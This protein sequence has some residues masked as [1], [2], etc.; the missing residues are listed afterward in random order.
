MSV[1]PHVYE[2]SAVFVDDLIAEV[3]RPIL[4]SV[5]AELTERAAAAMQQAIEDELHAIQRDLAQ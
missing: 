2:L 5:R 4:P 3:N 1:D